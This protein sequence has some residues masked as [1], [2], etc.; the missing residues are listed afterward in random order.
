[1]KM[2]FTED[3]TCIPNMITA[4]YIRKRL[5][6]KSKFVDKDRQTD[7]ASDRSTDR[8][9][10]KIICLRLSR[11]IKTPTSKQKTKQQEPNTN[12]RQKL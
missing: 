3:K 12:K 7:S 2:V 6:A 8:Q 4:L 10:P 9:R 11:S 5:L 1:M